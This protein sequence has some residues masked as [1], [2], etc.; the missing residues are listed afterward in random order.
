MFYYTR[1]LLLFAPGIM[2]SDRTFITTRRPMDDRSAA[3]VAR[4]TEAAKLAFTLQR[5]QM[6]RLAPASADMSAVP[7]ASAAATPALPPAGW[8]E[9]FDAAHNRP[10]FFNRTTNITQWERPSPPA[11]RPAALA[12]PPPAAAMPPPAAPSRAQREPERPDSATG[13]ASPELGAPARGPH[14]VNQA[15]CEAARISPR[16]ATYSSLNGRFFGHFFTKQRVLGV[17]LA[18]KS[19]HFI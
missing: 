9:G 1:T 4:G 12:M 3:A 16:G 15:D 18:D 7:A 2:L 19:C 14:E 11:Q 10:Y 13:A 6:Q 8:V 17:I 5:A